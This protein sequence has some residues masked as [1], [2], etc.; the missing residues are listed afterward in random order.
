[1][2]K[3]LDKVL[4]YFSWLKK[5]QKDDEGGV[6]LFDSQGLSFN[7]RFAQVVLQFR[8]IGYSCELKTT[9]RN[10]CSKNDYG[11]LVFDNVTPKKRKRK[12]D[13]V[14]CGKNNK[15]YSDMKKIVFNDDKNNF[16]TYVGESLYYPI[17]MH[18]LRMVT[19]YEADIKAIKMEC[20]IGVIFIGNT[21]PVV[22]SSCMETLHNQF[23]IF[24]R[25]E[26]INHIRERL[27]EFVFEPECK[28]EFYEA[29]YDE[30]RPL[31]KKIV[32]IDKIRIVGNDYLKLLKASSFHIWTSGVF[33][34][35]C[36][37]QIEGMACGCVPIYQ[38]FD[39][40]P[41]MKVDTN[42]LIYNSFDELDQL[43]V[44]AIVEPE[45]KTI[46]RRKETEKIYKEYFSN[47]AFRRK[48]FEFVHGKEDKAVFYVL[49]NIYGK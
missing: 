14:L 34:P 39:Y 47:Q 38:A 26:V 48:I 5:T 17:H 10:F 32:L 29:F 2:L 11:D 1:M 25:T 30:K 23:G 7:R 13:F 3:D 28:E 42:C 40:Y 24:T 20:K 4:S 27:Q 16:Q 18:P 37:N 9:F 45:E 46:R 35:Y 12:Y 8:Q 21:D 49:P 19:D 33:H 31:Q 15:N 43:L 44:Q 36:H 41:G 6:I 22:Y